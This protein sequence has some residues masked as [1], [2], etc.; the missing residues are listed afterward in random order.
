M[1][2]PHNSGQTA[3]RSTAAG[4]P[5]GVPAWAQREDARSRRD[6][7]AADR[8]GWTMVLKLVVPVVMVLLAGVF[9]YFGLK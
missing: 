7:A 6:E 1:S 8:E 4:D 9:S 5:D 3:F 2:E